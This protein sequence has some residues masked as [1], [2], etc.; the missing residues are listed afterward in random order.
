[1]TKIIT[2]SNQKGGVGK[3]TT[4]VHL[5]CGLAITRAKTL[6]VDMDAQG[7][8]ATLLGLAAE[9]GVFN[10]LV[11][12]LGAKHVV[13]VTE[14]ENLHV[15]LGDKKSI[16]AETVLTVQRVPI[17][18]TQQKITAVTNDE[19]DYV[20]IDTGPGAGELQ[21]QALWAADAV[22]IPCTTD[23][24]ATDGIFSI[25]QTLQELKENARWP[26]KVLGIL[27]T[28]FD[29]VTKESKAT[30]GDLQKH[31]PGE[32][33]PLAIHRATILRECAAAGKTVFELN[34]N[35]RAAQEYTQL[36]EWVRANF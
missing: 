27:P 16:T 29:T 19:Y 9:S 34:K 5:A 2:V 24:L 17:S 15:I 21:T 36:V 20:I 18:F 25:K 7:Q 26:G 13:R 6:L 3:T 1:M 23:Y 31:F 28:L 4:A 30:M 10:L 11:A 14:R 22:L 12:E 35:G 32:L 8:C 33:L